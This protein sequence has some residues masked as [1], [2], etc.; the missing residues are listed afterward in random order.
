MWRILGKDVSTGTD[1]KLTARLTGISHPVDVEM[2]TFRI[3]ADGAS[4][5]LGGYSSSV[6]F[7][8]EVLNRSFARRIEVKDA[9][10]QAVLAMAAKMLS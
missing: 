3:A 8:A 6:P 9:K 7:V 5:E 10:A 1:T 2:R 4:V